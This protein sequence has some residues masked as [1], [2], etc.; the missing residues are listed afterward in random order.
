MKGALSSK[1][2]FKFINDTLLQHQ[3]SN[4]LYESW[5]RCNNIVVSWTT[6]AL[7]PQIS[8][9]TI[10]IDSAYDMWLDL[11]DPFTKGNHFQMSYLLQEIHSM[12]Q[13]TSSPSH[14]FWILDSGTSDQVYKVKYKVDGSI[15]RHKAGLVAKGFNQVQGIDFFDTYSPIAKLTAIQLLLAIASWMFTI[16]RS[17]C[18]SSWNLRRRNLYATN[19]CP[20][21]VQTKPSISNQ[22]IDV[23]TKPMD[24]SS[25]RDFISKLAYYAYTLFYK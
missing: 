20:H 22:L 25:F 9:S 1:N 19:S 4:P 21:P 16:R 7:S 12:R 13:G 14:L 2:K 18:L 3:E 8:Q 10:C 15:E 11:Q 23:L 6:S 24:P 17:Q 5:D